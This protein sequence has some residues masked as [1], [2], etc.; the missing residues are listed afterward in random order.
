M[1]FVSDKS[2]CTL[3]HMTSK[4]I[5]YNVFCRQ[6]PTR[7]SL[8]SMSTCEVW[9]FTCKARLTGRLHKKAL[10]SGTFNKINI[11]LSSVFY[12]DLKRRQSYRIRIIAGSNVTHLSVSQVLNSQV[13]WCISWVFYWLNVQQWK[14][15]WSHARLWLIRNLRRPRSGD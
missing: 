11:C 2:D 5:K 13:M 8:G 7:L 3:G 10:R 1:Y 12:K 9:T 4:L 15:R 14:S 6:P